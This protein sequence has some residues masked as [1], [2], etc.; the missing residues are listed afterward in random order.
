MDDEF[1]VLERLNKLMKSG[2]RIEEKYSQTSESSIHL[3]HPASRRADHLEITLG[4]DG[5]IW[6]CPHHRD[7]NFKI[8]PEENQKFEL[9][10]R[11]VPKPSLWEK[12]EDARIKVFLWALF[13]VWIAWLAL[14]K[15]N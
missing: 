6:G 12:S 10:M 3:R 5:T 1:P 14:T 9:F 2:Y 4:N 7:I 15:N 11:S 8:A 13:P